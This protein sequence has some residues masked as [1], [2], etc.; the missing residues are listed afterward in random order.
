MYCNLCVYSLM[1]LFCVTHIQ[2]HLN[3]LH[4]N[5][6][7]VKVNKYDQTSS[8]ITTTII[9]CLKGYIFLLAYSSMG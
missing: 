8:M 7:F 4:S 5:F 9:F 1:E 2:V 3:Y 6:S